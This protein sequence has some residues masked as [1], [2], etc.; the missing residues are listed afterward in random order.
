M[1]AICPVPHRQM[2]LLIYLNSDWHLEK[3]VQRV[4]GYLRIGRT[5]E[6]WGAEKAP[7]VHQGPISCPAGYVHVSKLTRERTIRSSWLMPGMQDWP[8]SFL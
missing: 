5:P 6:E 8:V 2:D 4:Q 1:L 3:R 7:E